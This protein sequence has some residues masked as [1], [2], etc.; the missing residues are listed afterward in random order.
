MINVL[1]RHIVINYIKLKLTTLK[2]WTFI[3]KISLHSYFKLQKVVSLRKKY[4]NYKT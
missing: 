2:K 1:T 3:L 4:K